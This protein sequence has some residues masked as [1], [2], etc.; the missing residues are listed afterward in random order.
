V[1]HSIGFRFGCSAA[2]I[3]AALLFTSASSKACWHCDAWQEPHVET[4]VPPVY[5]TPPVD[6]FAEPRQYAPLNYGAIRYNRPC[7]VSDGRYSYPVSCVAL[8]NHGF[9]SAYDGW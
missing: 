8:A 7:L 6:M 4:F 1:F 9:I 2:S 5:A 3:A